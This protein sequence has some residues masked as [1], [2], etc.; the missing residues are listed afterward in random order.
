MLHYEL[1]SRY[2]EHI[3][4]VFS[5]FL[6]LK[7][8]WSL[9]VYRKQFLASFLTNGEICKLYYDC[10]MCI[11]HKRTKLLFDLNCP[12]KWHVNVR[13]RDKTRKQKKYNITYLAVCGYLTIDSCQ[14]WLVDLLMSLEAEKPTS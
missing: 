7:F 12:V 9:L 11:I 10:K 2:Y 1:S 4:H 14:I 8:K 3:K 5:C 13:I 6:M